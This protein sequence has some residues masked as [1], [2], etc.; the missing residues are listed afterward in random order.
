[1]QIKME[2]SRLLEWQVSEMSGEYDL[3]KSGGHLDGVLKNCSS[4]FQRYVR[5]EA[6]REYSSGKSQMIRSRGNRSSTMRA[7]TSF[8]LSSPGSIKPSRVP[9]VDKAKVNSRSSLQLPRLE[10]AK[11]LREF[12]AAR[13]DLQTV[14]EDIS[15]KTVNLSR[16]VVFLEPRLRS[17]SMRSS[18]GQLTNISSMSKS[19]FWLSS[20]SPPHG[21]SPRSSDGPHKL[22]V[23]AVA[24]RQAQL[25][26]VCPN[27]VSQSAMAL[28]PSLMAPVATKKTT[29]EDDIACRRKTDLF[30][31][32]NAGDLK[33]RALFLSAFLPPTLF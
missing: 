31:L 5:E 22:E 16:D 1:M 27:N 30:L 2:A 19:D 18:P 20:P 26:I 28:P 8:S 11:T 25:I 29:T 9:P 17:G 14:C 23:A 4:A 32:K 7:S 13:D 24:A 21:R 12:A 10:R 15:L 33:A 3:L 6:S